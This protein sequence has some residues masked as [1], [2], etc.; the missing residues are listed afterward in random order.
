MK[1]IEMR[2]RIPCSGHVSSAALR[3]E[4]TD[5]LKRN[6]EIEID[7]AKGTLPDPDTRRRMVAHFPDATVLQAF[8]RG[9]K[10]K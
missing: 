7:Y 5:M 10:K 3:A 1:T 6:A 8:Q 9:A 2:V 4:L